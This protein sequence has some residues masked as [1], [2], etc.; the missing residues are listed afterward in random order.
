[1]AGRPARSIDVDEL[2]ELMD[3]CRRKGCIKLIRSTD[4]AIELLMGPAPPEKGDKKPKD[5]DPRKKKREHY[6]LMLGRVPTDAE[7]DMLP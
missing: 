7:L 3:L 1:M 6:S 2:G 4:G 5:E